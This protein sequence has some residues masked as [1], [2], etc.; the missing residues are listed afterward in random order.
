RIDGPVAGALREHLLAGLVAEHDVGAPEPGAL[1]VRP[2]EGRGRVHVQ[3]AR[4]ADADLLASRSGLVARTL[5]RARDTGAL[6]AEEALLHLHVVDR[7]ARGGHLL[8][9]EEALEGELRLVADEVRVGGGGLLA[10]RHEREHRLLALDRALLAGEP[11]DVA[12]GGA[13]GTRRV[14]ERALALVWAEVTD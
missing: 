9:L 11:G 7:G 6:D 13:V 1:Q 12:A 5:E 4:H 8:R 10:L 14:D 2:E 3:H